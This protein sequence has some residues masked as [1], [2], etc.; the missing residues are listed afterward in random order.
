LVV[1]LLNH[2]EFPDNGSTI[3]G[4]ELRKLPDISLPQ[5]SHLLTLLLAAQ[6]GDKPAAVG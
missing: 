6:Q 3:S 5:V 2:V 4:E 1:A